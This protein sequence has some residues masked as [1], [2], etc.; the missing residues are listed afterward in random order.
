MIMMKKMMMMMSSPTMARSFADYHGLRSSS[1]NV[2]HVL[3]RPGTGSLG[4]F[5]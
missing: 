4:L 5:A 1:R 2:G 3:G